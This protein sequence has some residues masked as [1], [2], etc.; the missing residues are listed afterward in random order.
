M[1]R[2]GIV[3]LVVGLIV[4]AIG[5]V[6]VIAMIA[7]EVP[8]A[9]RAPLTTPVNQVY[10][11]DKATYDLYEQRNT[12]VA[13]LSPT[14]VTVTAPDG[15]DVPTSYATYSG[16]VTRSGMRFTSVVKFSAPVK[17]LYRIRVTSETP[18]S[19]VLD[20]DL[21]YLGLRVAAF[22]LVGL[23]GGALVIVAVV[24]LIVRSVKNRNQAQNAAYYPY[25]GTQAPWV[26]NGPVASTRQVYAAEPAP[27]NPPPGWYDDPAAPGTGRTRYWDGN[28]WR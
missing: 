4:G 28:A 21:E 9:T 24:V 6:G 22:F 8:N 18:R 7:K 10:S 20:Q 27:A 1:K 5:V 23:F 15:S 11:L 14:D 3:F 16:T 26:P 17:G 2:T 12:A 19:V 25:A 13:A